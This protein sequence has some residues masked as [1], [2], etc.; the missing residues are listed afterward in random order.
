[1]SDRR[2]GLYVIDVINDES[3]LLGDINGDENIDV[4]DIVIVVDFVLGF[5][6][7]TD[8]Q[9]YLSDINQDQEVDI[10]DIVEMVQIILEN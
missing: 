6:T 10:L 1:M 3:E 7:P 8:E 2:T 9:F 4:L 5:S